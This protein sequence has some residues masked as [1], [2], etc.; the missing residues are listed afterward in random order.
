MKEAVIKSICVGG[1]SFYAAACLIGLA[2]AIVNEAQP[3]TVAMLATAAVAFILVA[4][5]ITNKK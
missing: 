3:A 2:K 5:Y 4:S 1:A